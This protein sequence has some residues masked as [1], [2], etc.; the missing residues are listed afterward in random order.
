[1]AQDELKNLTVDPAHDI[2]QRPRGLEP[3]F[4]PQNVAVIG[5]TD[6]AG[7]VGRALVR[8]LIATPFGGAVLPV[9][10]KRSSIM[11][12]K[13]Y[14][15]VADLPVRADLA[16]I[17]TPAQIVPDL[18]S[19]CGQAGIKNVIVI[20]A[21]FKENGPEGL[22]L[23]SRMVANA[24]QH[25]VRIIGPNC[26]GVMMPPT[27]LNATFAH[28]MAK[29]GSVGFIS[30]SGALCTAVLD[31]SLQEQVGFSAFISIG[32]MVDVGWGDLIDYLGDDPLTR[33]IVL[34]M[35]S[36]GDAR[37][38]LSAA[39]EVAISKPIIVIKAGR[40]AAA[41]AAAVSHTGTL[42]GADDAMEAAFR[43][44]G[45][46]RVDSIQELFSMAEVLGKQPRPT[47]KR[48]TVV[49]NAGGPGVL[50]TDA[51]ILGQGELAPLAPETR[52]QL[53]ALLPA[54]WSK[55][56]PIDILGDADAK[57]YAA[58]IKIA[59]SDPNSDGLLII[60]TPQAMT[61]PTGTAEALVDEV[62][63]VKKPVLASWMGGAE[64]SA[65]V[66]RLSAAGIPTFAYPD[67]AA[68]TFNLMWRWA[69][70]LKG[71]YETPALAATPGDP[72]CDCA[73][74][75]ELIAQ[76]RQ[77]GRTTLT[78]P[79]AKE[80]LF[81]YGIPVVAT[82]IATTRDAAIAAA[83]AIGFPVVVKLYSHSIT[84][85]TEV[86]GVR[87][88]LKSAADVGAAFDQI[89]ASV[90]RRVGPAAFNGVTVQQMVAHDGY[91]I[92]LGSTVD[93]QLGPMI[94]F[95]TGGQL[96][97]V[98]RDRA[99][100]L[101]PLNTTLA[102]RMM[103]QTR[104]YTAL[105]GVRGR[106]PVDLV[107]LEEVIVRFSQ[108]IV[109]H[110]AIKEIDIN[111][112]LVSSR[113]IT[114]LDARIVLQDVKTAATTLPRTAIRPYPSQYMT[115]ITA[116]DESPLIVR[117]IR[118]EDEPLMVEFH[119]HLSDQ[120]VHQ[121][122]MG[123]ISYDSRVLHER[124]IRRC[125]NDYDREIALVMEKPSSAGRPAVILGVA[126]L[127]RIPHTTDARFAL[128]IADEY[129]HQGLGTELL[130]Q[131]IAVAR[132]E[133]LTHLGAEIL[134]SNKEMLSLCRHAGFVFNEKVK[135]DLVLAK[136]ALAPS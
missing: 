107:K 44:A 81:A 39:R 120:S 49:T 32:S 129:Q 93:L 79:E 55:G 118:P 99:L 50:A 45:V 48:L 112:L 27:G 96:V 29:S 114:A 131:L 128:V 100:A 134:S 126:R 105:K 109:E 65:G 3:F 31:W 15:S 13:A 62:K 28:A 63:G 51:L 69:Y 119:R 18:I 117:P 46:L 2:W 20:S 5:A 91:E 130:R 41:A 111:P 74:V 35:E 101:P 68:R 21:G 72:S 24:R 87:L 106:D 34:Y 26:L 92:I 135:D 22:A 78:E 89:Y 71:I 94:L 12:I 132:Q 6:K 104:I 125:F 77:A 80:L 14:P 16:V 54:H 115:R 30:Q 42:A 70:N 1:M 76:A 82:R 75:E 121:R 17:T 103:E 36:I 124:L 33:S 116:R 37:S 133:K 9:N 73:R 84:H 58:A 64:V 4:H 25:Q 56:N 11:G 113:G 10:L 43:R 19:E 52:D 23:E 86:D 122:Y 60:L 98:F 67:L 90:V 61:D 7:S 108:L 83:T 110:L 127:S 8:N 38:F 66:R 57:R 95:G 97:E 47:G 53:N 85:K 88:N 40:T 59:A 136:L 102:R 123:M